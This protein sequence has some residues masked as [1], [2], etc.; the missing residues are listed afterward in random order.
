MGFSIG[1][2]GFLKGFVEALA[3][4]CKG[5][6]GKISNNSGKRVSLVQFGNALSTI[7]KPKVLE[8]IN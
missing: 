3:S 6:F 1:L 5:Y 7:S 8:K 4:L 2:I